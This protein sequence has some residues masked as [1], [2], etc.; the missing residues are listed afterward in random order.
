MT[1]RELADKIDTL[2]ENVQEMPCLYLEPYDDDA[3]CY[4]VDLVQATENITDFA[5]VIAIVE[6]EWFLS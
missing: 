2:P 1:L 4:P 5:G 6:G 3:E